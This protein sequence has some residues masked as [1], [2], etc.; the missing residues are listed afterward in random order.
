MF[1]FY[2]KPYSSKTYTQ[3]EVEVELNPSLL[4]YFVAEEK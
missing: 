2:H 3:I 1:H 4:F